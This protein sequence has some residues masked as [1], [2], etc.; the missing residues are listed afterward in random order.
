MGALMRAK[1]W[2]QTALG[3]VEHWPESLRSAISICL[4]SR[5]PIV[6]Y[7]G[8]SLVVLYNDAYAE[9]LGKKHPWA[10][11]RLCREVWA[12]IWGVIAPMLEGV[13]TTGEATWSEDQ[14]LLLERR[15]YPEECYFSF[16]FSPVRG[17]SGA[18]DGIFTAV[19]ENTRR[20][21][22]ERRLRTLRD[23]GAL[24]EAKSAEEA[25]RIAASALSD[26]PDDVPFALLYLVDEEGKRGSLVA[27]TEGA[28]A[29]APDSFEIGVADAAGLPL[30]SVCRTGQPAL[31]G[32]PRPSALVL[33]LAAVGES[34]CSG[35]LLAG[36]SPRRD[37][38]VEYRG[39]FDL[40]ARRISAAIADARAYEEERRRA[41]ALAQID[42]AKTAFFSNV[43][44]EFR[45]PLTLML[46]P[47][48]ERLARGDA[49]HD[50]QLVHRNGLR[51]LRLVNTLLDFSRIEAGR[52]QASYEPTDLAALTAELASSFRS[53]CERAGLELT[54]ECPPLPEQVYV[55]RD[56]WEKIVLNL[57]SNA[58]KF[59]LQ[60][61][62]RVALRAA[63]GKAA[64][65][66]RDT[67]S[68]IPAEELPRMFERFHRV[69]GTRGR[70]HEG[71]GIGLALV[72]ELVKLHG[73]KV[74]VE[75]A[76]GEGSTFTVRVP[77]GAGH[78]DPR[79]V[80]K[81]P[82]LVS[83][84]T[85]PAAF[86]EEALHWQ[87]MPEAPEAPASGE[88]PRVVWAD[89]N[90]DMRAYVARLLGGQ[91]RVEAVAD[92]EAAL[93]AVR[94]ERP[95]VVLSDV[96]MPG[97]DGFG[98]LRALRADARSAEVPVILLS[99]RAGEESR[100][101]GAHA[102]ADDYLVKPFSAR[103][104]VARV[105]T[106][107][108]MSRHRREAREALEQ[109][110][111]RKDEFMA[112]LAHELRNPLAAIAMSTELLSRARLDD[113]RA[114]FAVPAIGRQ[115]KQL[116]RLADDL[117]DVARATYGK[118]RLRKERVELLGLARAVV[119]EFAARDA[120]GPKLEVSGSEAWVDADPARVRQMLEN[121][122]ENAIKYGGRSIAVRVATAEGG[123][124]LAVEDDGRGIE[125]SLVPDLLKP[126]VQGE[127]SLD[128]SQGG[129]G[130]G[131]ALVNQL[132]KLHG[133]QLEVHSAGP[134]T[135]ST[136]AFTLPAAA[137]PARRPPKKAGGGQKR[138]VLIVEDESDTGESLRLLL[139][140]DGHE[141]ALVRSGADGLAK[142]S[143]FRPDVALVD[144]GLPG[145]DGYEL[146][147]RARALPGG[148]LL[149]LI[150]LTGYGQ[151]KDRSETRGAGFD[152]HFTKPIPYEELLRA[153]R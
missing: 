36:V 149:K 14:L 43:S 94:R 34:R 21:L 150:A 76:L 75:S 72:R 58:F 4:G 108:R 91:F 131:L 27:R 78:L 120:G 16:S 93:A 39:F 92:G 69:K 151:E 7:W 38:D 147:R 86:V 111:R 123:A 95:D 31:V 66:V 148:E 15:G 11:G 137:A 77:F 42:R 112:M 82:G 50:L 110:D 135:G 136:F 116:Q 121:L 129:L 33:P 28:A 89:D 146:A 9:I 152:Q 145:M 59:T 153:F 133:G 139:E 97:L 65:T 8:P 62:I 13:I 71:T 32:E 98:L 144:I 113:K 134:G 105:E 23:L 74:K 46:G 54:V 10:L 124:S 48:E 115:A 55:D 61:G 40:I 64:L 85:G 20:V 126:F 99:A 70:T 140:S 119:Q 141:V 56:M 83:T 80:G 73:G 101:E 67:G 84:A 88:R 143:S 132:A 25:C 87:P 1:D 51:L 104:L 63:G 19:I 128:R 49:D 47:L 30:A 100:I 3:P 24:A 37:L 138:R 35:I 68:G 2:S 6:L 18:V 106:H 118:L 45:T 22:G 12:E 81:A 127:Q 96:M 130:L 103:E 29:R 90:A 17:L 60:G 5:F 117:L 114:R 57:V 53:A 109:A 125:P 52:L 122:V 102:G 142:L 41:E 79:H 107:A 26:K 44:H